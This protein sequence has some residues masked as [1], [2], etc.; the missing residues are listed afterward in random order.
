MVRLEERDRCWVFF[1]KQK[2]LVPRRN[3][4]THGMKK[5][6]MHIKSFTHIKIAKAET[7]N[8]S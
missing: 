2:D 3:R 8:L 7:D 1:P 5:F 4:K 6:G